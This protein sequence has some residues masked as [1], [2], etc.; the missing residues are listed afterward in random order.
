MATGHAFE[1]LKI[2]KGYVVIS[3]NYCAGDVFV[4]RQTDG[5]RMLIAQYC[6]QTVRAFLR[7]CTTVLSIRLSFGRHNNLLHNI[8]ETSRVT[9]T[10]AKTCLPT[11]RL[12][13][14]V[15][16]FFSSP[17]WLRVQLI[18][19]FLQWRTIIYRLHGDVMPTRVFFFGGGGAAAQ[20]RT[21]PPHF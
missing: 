11:R 18:G 9:F 5:N 6:P 17:Y 12:R 8:A 16:V 7:I 15:L 14:L 20:R 4:A 1:D 21:W 19:R 2:L 10:P 3:W 13:K